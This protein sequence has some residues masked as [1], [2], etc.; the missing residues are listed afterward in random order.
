M[1][2]KRREDPC[3]CGSGQKYKDCCGAPKGELVQLPPEDMKA[4]KVV[5]WT[6]GLVDGL[7]A[8]LEPPYLEYFALL[9]KGRGT[10]A[11]EQQIAAIPENKR[12]LTR[13]LDCLDSAF[14]DFDRETAK[15]DLPYMQHRQPEVIKSYLEFRLHQFASLLNAV[16]DYLDES[17]GTE[18]PS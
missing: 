14:A 11:A 10:E 8:S 13:I 2:E 18:D 6:P 1:S 17:S 3:D 9:A 15:L 7:V 16:S 4:I 12:Y 5:E